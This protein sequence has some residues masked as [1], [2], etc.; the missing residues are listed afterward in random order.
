MQ[1]VCTG[2]VLAVHALY[3]DEGPFQVVAFADLADSA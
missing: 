3:L 2:R 1:A